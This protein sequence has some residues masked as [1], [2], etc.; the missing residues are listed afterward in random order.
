MI[1]LTPQIDVNKLKQ[2]IEFVRCMGDGT[3]MIYTQDIGTPYVTD[4]YISIGYNTNGFPDWRI[5]A[6]KYGGFYWPEARQAV[7]AIAND[8]LGG[9]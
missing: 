8:I 6:T 1:D 3:V 4:M 2:A 9:Q 5:D 7:V